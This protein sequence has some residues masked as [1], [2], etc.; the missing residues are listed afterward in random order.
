MELTYVFEPKAD[1]SPL[2]YY[3][4]LSA[5]NALTAWKELALMAEVSPS[6]TGLLGAP[7]H[8]A[9]MLGMPRDW[10]NR[11]AQQEQELRALRSL[12]RSSRDAVCPHCL[13]QDM[14]LRA[15]WEHAYVTACIKHRVRLVDHCSTCDAPLDHQRGHIAQ[16]GCGQELVHMPCETASE[17]ELWLSGLLAGA[18]STDDTN[19]A[20]DIVGAAPQAVAELVRTLCQR[21]DTVGAPPRRNAASPKSVS[22]A[23]EFLT[24]LQ[25]LLSQWPQAYEAHVRSRMAAGSEQARTLKA[26]LGRWYQQL[27]HVATDGPLQ[28]FLAP[29][30]RI[31]AAEFDGVVG[32]EDVD[33]W[34]DLRYVRLSDAAQHGQTAQTRIEYAHC[35]D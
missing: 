19:I 3:R 30:Q 23:V 8:I 15:N 13:E 6:R 10:T 12:H 18:G 4:R 35:H 5:A 17:A 21:A 14:Y 26:L 2:G 1:E 28:V 33:S 32:R 34:A 24:P 11:L 9:S 22:E 20:P 27:R 16:C 25:S 7:D 31:A 29:V